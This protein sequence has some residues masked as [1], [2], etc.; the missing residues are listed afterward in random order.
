MY[1]P[2]ILQYLATKYFFLVFALKFFKKLAVLY[3]QKLGPSARVGFFV[4]RLDRVAL[5]NTRGDDY[6]KYTGTK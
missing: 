2:S 1:F 4:A 3:L 6:A 5:K